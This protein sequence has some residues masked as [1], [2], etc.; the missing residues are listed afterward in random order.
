MNDKDERRKKLPV[1]GQKLITKLERDLS[2][3]HSRLRERDVGATNVLV[4][5][6]RAKESF[7]LEDRA[8]V[9]FYAHGPR[10][11]RHYLGVRWTE[12]SCLKVYGDGPIIVA[13]E[14][15]NLIGVRL[16]E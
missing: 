9:H 11:G 12:D 3:A 14:A 8:I 1:W 6:Y 7:H 13:P 16:G 4:N 15:A 10:A 5:P 2:A